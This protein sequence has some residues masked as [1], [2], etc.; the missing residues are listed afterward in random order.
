MYS[1]KPE[2][3]YCYDLIK[4]TWYIYYT[5]IFCDAC[6]NVSYFCVVCKEKHIDSES[7]NICLICYKKK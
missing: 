6:G 3:I 2:C 1:E 7:E 4:T 5:D